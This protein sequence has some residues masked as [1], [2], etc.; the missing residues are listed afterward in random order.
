MNHYG[1]VLDPAGER[2][3]ASPPLL[4]LAP[5]R[6]VAG[7]VAA[8]LL[9]EHH[10]DTLDHHHGFLVRY[11]RLEDTNL[12]FHADDAEVTL[13]LCLAPGFVG[14]DLWFEGARCALHRDDPAR[15]EERGE[16]AHRPGVAL[17]HAGADRHGAHAIEKGLRQNLILWMRSTAARRPDGPRPD[18][19]ED[20]CPAWC[21]SAG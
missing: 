12:A 4:D 14:G 21:P 5:L 7:P 18:G 15:P 8:A 2:D 17:L 13:N 20:L 11:A 19:W 16:W 10:G 9:P 6:A 1:L 3:E